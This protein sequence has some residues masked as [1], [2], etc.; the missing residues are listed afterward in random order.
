MVYDATKEDITAVGAVKAD[1]GITADVQHQLEDYDA[2]VAE[3]KA[4]T[5]AEHTLTLREGFR[6]YP[7]AMCWSVLLSSALIMNGFDIV[8][9]GSFYGLPQFT[10]KY[11]IQLPDGSHT[12]TAAWQAGLSN[13]GKAGEIIGLAVNGWA[14][15]RF[16]CRKAMITALMYTVAV[17]FIPVFAQNIQT[18]LV[19]Q[20]LSGCAWGCFETMTTTY[21]ADIMPVQ[22]RPY[23]TAYVNL[24]WVVGQLIASG[25]LRGVLNIQSEWAFRIPFALQW[26]WPIPI[27]IGCYFAPE[28]PWWLVRTGRVDLARKSIR[29][30]L[31]DPTDEEIDNQVAMIVHTNAMEKSVSSGTSYWDCFKGIDLRRTEV[32]SGVWIIQT[33]C[34]SS[35][36]GYSTFF[37]IQAGL[38]TDSAFSLSIGQYAMGMVGTITSWFMMRYLGRRTLYFWGLLIL[39]VLLVIIGVMGCITSNG[40][41]W[42]VGAM[43]LVYTFF[44]DATIGPVCYTLVAEIP[45]TRLRPKTVV[46]ARILYNAMSIVTGI[47]MPY[48]LNTDQLNWGAKTG[49]F[50]AGLCGLCAAWTYFRCPEPR[51]RTYGELDVL[52]HN[53]VSARKFASTEVDQFADLSHGSSSAV[54]RSD[55]GEKGEEERIEKI[56]V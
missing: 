21:A 18:L 40:A 4:A 13:G 27:A 44:Y 55:K 11:G 26:M 20:I 41:Q 45:S 23:L 35:L 10:K 37:L 16:G 56:E 17:I 30:L 15:E 51:G 48:F 3:A 42:A 53:K 38:A 47:I 7:A 52:F 31:T 32:A 6:R 54:G 22:L 19:G 29:R 33:I 14:M 36:M 5:D 43:L 50:W 28:S 12:I 25:V 34:G 24:C 39:L 49:F 2:V 46:I 1:E 8:L 9:M